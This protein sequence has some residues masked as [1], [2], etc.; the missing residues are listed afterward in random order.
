MPSTTLL[1]PHHS[2]NRTVKGQWATLL[3][4]TSENIDMNFSGGSTI[5]NNAH[6]LP[7]ISLLVEH[8]QWWSWNVVHPGDG[9]KVISS[10]EF[11]GFIP[12]RAGMTMG[13][14]DND[15]AGIFFYPRVEQREW[16][17]YILVICPVSTIFRLIFNMFCVFCLVISGF[18]LKS[19][20]FPVFILNSNSPLVSGH[21][22]FLMCHR[23]D[24]LP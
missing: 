12:M 14:F 21:L 13:P 6:R 23:S 19:N 1:K 17:L 5:N 11:K 4:M 18:I 7:T 20:S 9:V 8:S 22:P 10:F 2:E 24:C 16:S 3:K 15:K